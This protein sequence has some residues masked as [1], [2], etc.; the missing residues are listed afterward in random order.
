MI[1]RRQLLLAAGAAPLIG[2]ERQRPAPPKPERSAGNYQLNVDPASMPE[3]PEAPPRP[4]AEAPAPFAG[5]HWKISYFLDEA[6]RNLTITGLVHPA[7]EF[8]LAVGVLVDTRRGGT[9]NTAVVT[10]DGGKSWSHVRLPRPPVSVFALDAAHVWLV[11]GGR[12][13]F[14]KDQGGKWTRLRLPR[15]MAQVCFNTPLTGF[16]FGG[17]K[18][19]HRTSDGGQNW[20]PVAEG[21]QLKLTD[22][23]TVFHAMS[24]VNERV[25]LLAG[26]S[27]RNQM[28]E[29]DYLPAW[30]TPER[31]LTRRPRP[32]T[33]VVLSTLDGGATWSNSVT[34][35][36][37]DIERVRLEGTRGAAL[38]SYGEGFVW[39]SEVFRTDLS[40]GKN[41][42]LFRRKGVRVTDVSLT[43]QSGYL[44]AAI[45]P[46]GRLPGAGLP[47]RL[48]IICSPDG[49]EWFQMPVDYRAQGPHALLAGHR[50]SVF[51][52]L[53]NG[54][55]LRMER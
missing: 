2:Q 5:A 21:A 55:I 48:R 51:V 7:P 35:A 23:T 53:A 36:F 19:F 8:A 46:F 9:Q 33:T 11:G 28:D 4:A 38:F 37:G 24:F 52:A 17:G 54:M 3:I 27:R 43:G 42:S 22:E 1:S 18:T 49:I 26:N 20:T 30:M 15:R 10:L 25:G 16:A 29:D 12:L 44:L 32:A 41:E 31:A 39:P 34:S 6:D 45:E 50:E 47:G 14:S 13:Y 40:T